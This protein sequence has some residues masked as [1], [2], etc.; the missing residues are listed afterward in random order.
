MP[1]QKIVAFHKILVFITRVKSLHSQK[2]NP[3]KQQINKYSLFVGLHGLQVIL[4]IRTAVQG[5][6]SAGM[7]LYETVTKEQLGDE[8]DDF[9]SLLQIILFLIK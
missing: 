1:V 9:F 5:T 7:E 4:Y 8:V 6:V 2:I 3:K